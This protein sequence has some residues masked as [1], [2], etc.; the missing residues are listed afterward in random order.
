LTNGN[1]ALSNS[2][3]QGFT[4]LAFGPLNQLENQKLENKNINSI[5]RMNDLWIPL[6]L[7]NPRCCV[8]FY[9]PKIDDMVKVGDCIFKISH[10]G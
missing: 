9:I 8:Q 5:P 6:G 2:V 10:I 1:G 4:S 3:K 7:T